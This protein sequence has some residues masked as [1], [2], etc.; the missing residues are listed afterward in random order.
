MRETKTEDQLLMPVRKKTST[1]SRLLRFCS[2]RYLS[3]ALIVRL[4][5]FSGIARGTVE[6]K[7][8]L[9]T[10]SFFA[11]PPLPVGTSGGGRMKLG[12]EDEE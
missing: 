6:V 1:T 11:P 10:P 12:E 3:P 8:R 4:S 5:A 9:P 7:T 2:L